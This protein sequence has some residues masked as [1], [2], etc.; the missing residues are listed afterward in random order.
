MI[1]YPI[2]ISESDKF[3]EWLAKKEASAPDIGRHELAYAA[4][5]FG[6]STQKAESDNQATICG[7]VLASLVWG[8][9]WWL[10]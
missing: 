10:K 7:M 5:E 6:K 9:F 1:T 2:R 4:F 3:K 8:V